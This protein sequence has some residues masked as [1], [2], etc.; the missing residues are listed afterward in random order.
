MIRQLILSKLPR[1]GVKGEAAVK[2][3]SLCSSAPLNVAC[4]YAVINSDNGSQ[5]CK[6]L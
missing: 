2:E 3:P 5:E 6:S 4:A 1:P